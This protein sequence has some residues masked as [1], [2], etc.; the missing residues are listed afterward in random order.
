MDSSRR[1][2]AHGIVNDTGRKTESGGKGGI[3]GL[4]EEVRSE[5]EGM[6]AMMEGMKAMMEGIKAMVEGTGE[7]TKADKD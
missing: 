4:K 3:E 2:G 6:K 1:A 7:A 5:A